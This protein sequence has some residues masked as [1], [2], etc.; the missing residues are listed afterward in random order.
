MNAIITAMG[1][2]ADKLNDCLMM[3]PF[4]VLVALASRHKNPRAECLRLHRM[5][6]GTCRLLRDDENA[7]ATACERIG[8]QNCYTSALPDGRFLELFNVARSCRLSLVNSVEFIVYFDEYQDESFWE[9]VNRDRSVDP[10]V[11]LTLQEYYR[12]ALI[13]G[14]TE[15]PTRAILHRVVIGPDGEFS[16]RFAFGCITETLSTM[17]LSSRKTGTFSAEL[18]LWAGQG[19]LRNFDVTSVQACVDSLHGLRYRAVPG[20]EGD[21]N[22][23]VS[24]F[25]EGDAGELHNH[26]NIVTHG[27]SRLFEAS[28]AFLPEL[29]KRLQSIGLPTPGL[30]WDSGE[31]DDG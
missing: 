26:G 31:E 16:I 19:A 21:E 2:L 11:H 29:E 28:D 18:E 4:A 7:L 17:R 1:S 5:L 14:G 25:F 24:I 20:R 15:N 27:A 3:H 8:G 30:A 9:L 6:P 22:H 23:V 13:G 12:E 10:T